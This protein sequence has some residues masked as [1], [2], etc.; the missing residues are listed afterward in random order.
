VTL[1]LRPYVRVEA[2][3]GGAR[4]LDDA[5][6]QR[7]D[8][9]PN[10]ARLLALVDGTRSAAELVQTPEDE[11]AIR[12][13][14][15]LNLVEGAGDEIVA[16]IHRVVGDR[17]RLPY[18][19]LEGARFQCQG[20]GACCQNYV[21]G[22]LDD[23]DVAA[24]A[25]LPIAETFPRLAG[26]D[27][28]VMKRMEGQDLRFLRSEGERCAFLQEDMRCGLHA[29]FGAEAKPKICRLY[30]HEYVITAEGVRIFDK[31]SCATFAVS[32]RSGPST[33]DE[34]PRLR[35]LLP[36]IPT[37][38][39]HPAVI[40]DEYPCDYGHYDRFVKTALRLV[41]AGAGT[42]PETLRAISRGV[43]G[44]A[45]ILRSFPL[46]AGEP[47]ASIGRFLDLDPLRWYDGEPPDERVREG[48][49]RYA[50]VFTTFLMSATNKLS[51][52]VP[53]K[54]KLS[55][56]LV[57][58]AAQLFHLCAGAAAR[59]GDESFAVD[60][61]LLKVAAVPVD[62]PEVDELLRLSLRQQLFGTGVLVENRALAALI[63]MALIQVM[64]VFGA[65]LRAEEAGRPAVRPE[66][67]SWGQMLAVRLLGDADAAPILAASEDAFSLLLEALPAVLALAYRRPIP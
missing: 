10:A 30:P 5:L 11:P 32:A 22:P 60:E 25:A 50:E 54:G 20:S 53:G 47:D 62:D 31:G 6:V 46:V 17:E 2:R 42:A 3:E 24:L 44:F 61:Y 34:L 57:R 1:R 39:H 56:P 33:A 43:R 65:R 16:R 15:L 48:A 21:F 37:R 45:Q 19:V 14:F 66:D 12:R 55:L 41:R 58:E 59:A 23:E 7:Y 51:T 36:Q 63:R 8:V 18:V 9:G 28:V 64:A 35:K 27:V 40:V 4:I 67:L 29:R 13:L 38:L 52:E 49:L 26:K